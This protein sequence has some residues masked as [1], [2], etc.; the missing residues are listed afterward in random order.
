VNNDAKKAAMTITTDASRRGTLLIVVAG[1]ASVLAAMTLAFLARMRSDGEE[2]ALIQREFQARMM[3]SAGLQY[4]AECSRLGWDVADADPDT[5]HQE[6]FGWIDQR[7]GGIGP[8]DQFNRPLFSNVLTEDG[9][10]DG[11][12]DR[13]TW[14]AVGSVARAPAYVMERAP[15]AV[16]PSRE[17]PIDNSDPGKPWSDLINHRNLDPQPVKGTW[18]EFR[19]GDTRPRRGTTS[20]AWFRVHRSGPAKFIVTC[21]AGATL[22]YKDWAE[23]VAADSTAIFTSSE[24]FD[25]LRRGEILLWYETEWSP[26][27]AGGPTYHY[28]PQRMKVEGTMGD[29]WKLN[30]IGSPRQHYW[31]KPHAKQHGGTFLYIERLGD[32]PAKW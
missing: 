21:G 29:D 24:Q 13:P 5:F 17:N 23:V 9:D 28:W 31:R 16:R 7:S 15:W 8:R 1:L 30:A 4:V 19:D 25:D 20:M 11:A 12:K 18:E 14:P 26:A 2:S 32:E 6:G 22:G 10:G 3:L 27:V